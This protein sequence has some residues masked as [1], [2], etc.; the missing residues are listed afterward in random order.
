MIDTFLFFQADQKT[1]TLKEEMARVLPQVDEMRKRKVDRR[2]QF[3]EVLDQILKIS[4]EI[5]GS[6]FSHSSVAID[7]NDLSLRKLEELQEQLHTLQKEKV[8]FVEFYKFILYFL[9]RSFCRSLSH[10][11]K[12]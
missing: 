3:L 6:K 10:L 5:Y 1:G 9:G 8:N 7:E 11:V 4:Y 2:N 12:F